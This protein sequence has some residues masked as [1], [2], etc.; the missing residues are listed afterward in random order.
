MRSHG[1]SRGL[2]GGKVPP[3]R[4]SCPF[5]PCV[6]S[7]MSPK[8]SPHFWTLVSIC[9]TLVV[10]LGLTAVSPMLYRLFCEATGYEGTVRRAPVTAP[11]AQ[12]SDP[13]ARTVTVFFDSNVASGLPWEFRPEQ[14]KVTV[15]LGEPTQVYYY[16][17][18]NSDKTMVARAV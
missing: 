17:K 14:R 9:A 4:G 10:M 13:N 15:K 3:V 2:H 11:V 8:R 16:A 7:V 12:V 5:K 6:S 18:N 1:S